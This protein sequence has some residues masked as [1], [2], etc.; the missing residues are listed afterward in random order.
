VAP[1]DE[2]DEDSPSGIPSFEDLVEEIKKQE[3]GRSGAEETAD[4]AASGADSKGSGAVSDG[5]VWNWGGG[6]SDDAAGP[7]STGTG[8]DSL[9][10]ESESSPDSESVDQFDAS[11]AE[12]LV[13]LIDGASNVLLV[14]PTGV[15]V[16]H[17]I[18]SQLCDVDTDGNRRRLLI[19]TEHSADERLDALRPYTDEPFDETTIIVVGDQVR[20]ND[21][22]EPSTQQVGEETV[23]IEALHDPMDLTRLGVLINK[24]LGKGETPP[25]ICFHTLNGI[26]QFVGIEKMFRFLHILQARVRSVGGQAHYQ[27]DPS[28][29]EEQSVSTLRSLF[30]FTIWYDEDGSISAEPRS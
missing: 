20:S 25:V 30:D 29:V 1:E 5:D 10:G 11:K 12:A 13:E 26:L 16:G 23:V 18:C 28:S 6:E 22:S 17:D 21:S 9:W 2:G 24:Y 7:S 19:T 8:V 15:P 14:G 3:K 4:T 27:I